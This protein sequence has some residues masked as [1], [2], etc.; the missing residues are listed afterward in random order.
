[1]T[2]RAMRE[3]N[4]EVRKSL[5]TLFGEVCSCWCLPLLPQ[6][7]CNILAT[8]YRDLFSA[9]YKIKCQ[10]DN[11]EFQGRRQ[12]NLLLSCHSLCMENSPKA[13]SLTPGYG[14][15]PDCIPLHTHI[16]KRRKIKQRRSPRFLWKKSIDS[17][18]VGYS[19]SAGCL[20]KLAL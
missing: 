8:T 15:H 13:P 19:V 1:M 16:L 18:E 11:A 12:K 4:T 6:L 5:C 2:K 9:L 7:A 20:C 14:L 10:L 17:D 3:F